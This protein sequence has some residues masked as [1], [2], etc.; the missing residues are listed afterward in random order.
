MNDTGIIIANTPHQI[1]AYRI[2]ALKAAL[3]LEIKGLKH[4]RGISAYAIVK[5]EFG[6]K[7]SKAK[8]LTQLQHWVDINLL[9][10]SV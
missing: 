7:G 1:R 6:F 3:G 4:S 10:P 9:S 2:L 5:K 8:V